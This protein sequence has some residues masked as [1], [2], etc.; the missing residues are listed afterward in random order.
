MS[1]KNLSSENKKELNIIQG[2]GEAYLL[3]RSKWREY[4]RTQGEREGEPIIIPESRYV[5]I[6]FPVGTE[7]KQIRVFIEE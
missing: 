4:T 3:F 1:Y 5:S 6:R 2:L 7:G